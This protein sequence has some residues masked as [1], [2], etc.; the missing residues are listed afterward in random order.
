MTNDEADCLLEAR[1]RILKLEREIKRMRDAIR[2]NCVVRVGD[3]LMVQDW[4]RGV[5]RDFDITCRTD[6]GSERSAER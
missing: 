2:D 1:E 3:Q 5:I 4:V 6:D